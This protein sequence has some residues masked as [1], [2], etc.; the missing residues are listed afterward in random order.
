MG[1]V[2]LVCMYIYIERSSPLDIL[3]LRFIFQ[4]LLMKPDVFVKVLQLQCFCAMCAFLTLMYLL[5]VK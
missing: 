5:P 2:F 1:S 4:V 3:E